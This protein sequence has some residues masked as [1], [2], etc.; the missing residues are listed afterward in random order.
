MLRPEAMSRVLV[1]GPKDQMERVIETLYRLKLVHIVD[2]RGEDETFT[3][4]KPLPKAS[5]VSQQLVK[6]RSIASILKVEETKESETASEGGDLRGRIA[7][8]EVN[9]REDEEARKRIESLL[10]ELGRQME[11]LRPFASLG[12]PLE[13]YRGYDSLEVVVGRVGEPVEGLNAVV[14]TNEVIAA[15][16]FLAVFVPKGQADRVLEFLSRFGFTPLDVPEGEGD[17]STS[18]ARA[19]SDRKKWAAR[20]TEIEDRIATLRTKYARFVVRAQDALESEIEKAEA[21]LRFAA[22]EHSFVIDGWVP[23]T[24]VAELRASL[25]AMPGVEVGT[26]E[27][28]HETVAES[29]APPVLMKNRGPVRRFEFLTKLYS[30]PSHDEADPTAFLFLFFPF[31]FGLMIGDAGY[32]IVM[33]A[34]GFLLSIKFKDSRDFAD[35][36]RVMLFGGIFAFL[37]GLFLYGEIFGIPYH[38]P[39]GN[40]GEI[41]WSAILGY[42]VPYAPPIHKLELFG[43][44]D[45]LLLSIVAAFIHLTIGYVVGFFNEVHHDRKHALSRVGWLFVLVGLFGFFVVL[46]RSPDLSNPVP[47]VVNTL[48]FDR[49]PFAW[50][51]A[52]GM[53]VGGLTVPYFSIASMV[54]GILI[55]L[56]T[57]GG[58]ALVETISLLANMMSYTRLAGIAVAKG[59]VVLAFNTMLLPFII[60]EAAFA[61]SGAVQLNP[62]IVSVIV[63]FV[64]LFFAHLIIL[65]LGSVSAGIQALRL[66]YVE[67]FLKFYKG[68]GQLFSPF[69]ARKTKTEA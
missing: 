64:L 36:M 41:S 3:I 10:Q 31:F 18:L 29:E 32:G 50:I 21:P 30:P 38:A 35:L 6:L 7:A 47:R 19:E 59:A 1:V 22:S 66:N 2:H 12:L 25:T 53:V 67:F 45:L 44:V 60:D 15:E 24:N 27:A 40:A 61:A 48:F 11:A 68:G 17:P 5:E 56:P 55:L 52:P 37:F 9:L 54:A 26:S 69:G 13:A 46:G 51:P 63:G 20:R 65:I 58:L 49:P 42:Y 16:G 23:E 34:L 57:E 39:T 43:V 62:S 28:S 4:G 8:L 33:I 14:P